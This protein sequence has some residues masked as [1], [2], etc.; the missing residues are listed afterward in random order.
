MLYFYSGIG[1]AF[2]ANLQESTG[3][4]VAVNLLTLISMSHSS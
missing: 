1:F 2:L 3:W 4:A